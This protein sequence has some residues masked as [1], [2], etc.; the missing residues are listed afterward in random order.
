MHRPVLSLSTAVLI[1]RAVCRLSPDH[2]A[3][4]GAIVDSVK[5][6]NAPEQSTA[7]KP[8]DALPAEI[9]MHDLGQSANNVPQ[10]EGLKYVRTSDRVLLVRP[11]T[12]VVVG[13][14]QSK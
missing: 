3:A 9:A 7:A 1:A 11:E 10:L 4:A 6:A 14:L 2:A 12:S 8:A 5:Q 13:E